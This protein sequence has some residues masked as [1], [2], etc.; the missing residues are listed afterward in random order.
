[1][2]DM[3]RRV[4]KFFSAKDVADSKTIRCVIDKILFD[5]EMRGGARDVLTFRGE[6]KQLV[7][8]PTITKYLMK[9]F[10]EDSDLWIGREVEL[11]GS[12]CS[13]GGDTVECVRVRIVKVAA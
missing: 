9:E 6:P 2:A 4:G 10:G 3:S 12:E 5:V 7:L 8:R 1:M 11:Y 13:F